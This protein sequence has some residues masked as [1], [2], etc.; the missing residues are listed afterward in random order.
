[1]KQEA[2]R[3]SLLLDYYGGLLTEKQRTYFDFYYNQD[4]SLGEIAEQEGISRQGV[5]DAINRTETTLREIEQTLGC[6]A[7]ETR[8][9]QRLREISQAVQA[10][11][12]SSEPAVQE[13]ARRILLLTAEEF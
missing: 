2:Y 3:M 4:Y 9:R 8:L 7:R 11:Q 5:H 12:A 10:L 6:V 1:M 13:A